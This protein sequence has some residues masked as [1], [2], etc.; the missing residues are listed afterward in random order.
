[1]Q[2]TRSDVKLLA[3]LGYVIVIIN[4][5][6]AFANA[7]STAFVQTFFVLAFVG[8]TVAALALTKSAEDS[9]P[10]IN[11]VVLYAGG[12]LLRG[13]FFLIDA[14]VSFFTALRLDNLANKLNYADL[15]ERTTIRIT[16]KIGAIRETMD[17]DTFGE[18]MD[19]MCMIVSVAVAV[20]A[21]IMLIA[22]L[23]DRD[24]NTPI[25]KLTR[26]MIC[27]NENKA[28]EAVS[29][30]G[31]EC[32]PDNAAGDVSADEPEKTELVEIQPV[33]QPVETKPAKSKAKPVAE[34]KKDNPETADDKN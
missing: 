34:E 18:I 27:K 9:L 25:G 21:I 12:L 8:I 15:Q 13:I 24:S 20:A 29:E 17:K 23:R 28:D 16:D 3:V 19:V 31:A 2:Q 22:L 14:L 33:P 26:K 5:F 1:M 32:P 30:A 11:S 6:F 4:S 7:G 10:V